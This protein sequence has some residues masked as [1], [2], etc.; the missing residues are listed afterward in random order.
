MG[1]KQIL[2]MMAAVMSLSVTADEVVITDPILKEALGKQLKK[3]YGKFAPPMK[4]TEAELQKLT[5]LGLTS[6]KSPMRPQGRGQVAEPRRS[7]FGRHQSHR[8]GS[9]GRGQV[10]EAH[11]NL[12]NTQITDEGLKDVAKLQKLKMLGLESTRITDE[13]LKDLAKLQKLTVLFLTKPK[14]PMRASRTW[15][16]CRTSRLRLE[17]HPNHR[18]GPQGI[19]KLKKFRN[20]YLSPPK[21][22]TRDLK[23]VVKLQKFSE[24]LLLNNT[25]IAD[26]GLKDVAKLQKL[27]ILGLKLES[28]TRP[29]G[30]GQ[31]AKYIFG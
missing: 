24:K 11:R 8:R 16:R 22:P 2:V 26:D 23:E 6:P 21:S 13:G 29:Q 25:Q 14:S 1:M 4:L 9:Q 3:P 20:L 27:K 19:G 15:S 31:N 28:P 30:R 5:L 12:T 17:R 10:A 7:L 18:R